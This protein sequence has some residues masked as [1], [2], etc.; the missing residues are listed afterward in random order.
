MG[1]RFRKR[2]NIAPGVRINV[3]K[4]GVSASVGPRG[5]KLNFSRSGIRATTSVPGTGLSYSRTISAGTRPKHSKPALAR[6]SA[7]GDGGHQSPPRSSG[8]GRGCLTIFIA[9]LAIGLGLAM[10]GYLFPL[11]I[12]GALALLGLAWKKPAMVQRLVD[13][14]W[15]ARLPLWMRATPLRFAVVVA[16]I[17]I[18]VSTFAGVAVYGEDRTP[19]P[20]ATPPP[21]VGASTTSA[22]VTPTVA[23]TPTA[24]PTPTPAPVPPTPTPQ[25]APTATP[26]PTPQPVPTATPT[27]APISQPTD[28]PSSGEQVVHPGAFCSPVGAT[29]VTKTG[30]PMVCSTTPED[31]RPRWRSG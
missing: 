31:N 8:V 17:L 27:P 26:T 21:A 18:P 29:G 23:A 19:P 9:V 11:V 3:S 2:F 10:L 6:R 25:P 13:S 4:R 16:L 22:G 24:T 28:P 14:R 1:F 12:A 30:K 15:A 7:G 20:P 5:A